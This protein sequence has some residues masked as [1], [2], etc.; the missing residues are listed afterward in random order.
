MR[1]AWLL[2]ALGCTGIP[3]VEPLAAGS[4]TFPEGI[5]VAGPLPFE[6]TEIGKVEAEGW[7][8]RGA[9]EN[10]VTVAQGIG[11]TDVVAV[12]WTHETQVVPWR[13][14]GTEDYPGW[15]RPAGM[16]ACNEETYPRTVDRWTATG[17]AVKRSE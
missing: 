7:D 10:L 9:L 5:W 12:T 16:P 13:Q 2:L 11:A 6:W 8:N 15:E 4:L 3:K 17:V 14:C 1:H